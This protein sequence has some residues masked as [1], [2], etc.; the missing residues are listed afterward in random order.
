MIPELD[1]W[2]DAWALWRHEKPTKGLGL[3]SASPIYQMMQKVAPTS[4]KRFPRKR[5]LLR[6]GGILVSRDINGIHCRETAPHFY[7]RTDDNIPCEVMDK[8][9]C[10]LPTRQ[11]ILV[12]LKYGRN[13]GDE[14]VWDALRMTRRQ[15]FVELDQAHH[16]LQGWLA[17]RYEKIFNET[18]KL[19]SAK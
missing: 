11:R 17:G 19:L 5:Y 18:M 16:H 13:L 6:S 14:P 15:Y 9:V 12:K 2:L 4:S 7:Q 3:P 1:R 8:A 10:A